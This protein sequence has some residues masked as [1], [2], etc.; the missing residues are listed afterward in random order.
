MLEMSRCVAE[1]VSTPLGPHNV[2]RP[3]SRLKPSVAK[4]V[5]TI[6]EISGPIFPSVFKKK[7]YIVKCKKVGQS[8]NFPHID[9]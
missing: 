9:L 8:S 2:F 7:S 5:K 3:R 4:A 1:S 6:M